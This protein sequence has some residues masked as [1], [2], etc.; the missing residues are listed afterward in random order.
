MPLSAIFQLYHW[1]PEREPT[2][3]ELATGKLYHLA[4]SRLHP[5]VVQSRIGDIFLYELLGNPTT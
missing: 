4:A 3:M 5:F 2:T 1:R